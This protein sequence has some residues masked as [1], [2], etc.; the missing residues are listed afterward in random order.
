MYKKL[1]TI[2]SLLCLGLAPSQ[3]NA[4]QVVYAPEFGEGRYILTPKP[5]AAP[6]I[7][8]PTLF[9]VRPGN[10]FLYAIPATGERPMRFSVTALPE[11]LTVNR[12]NGHIEG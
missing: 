6:R 9:G 7:N 12:E 11:G 3:L 8:G 1:I 5:A 4:D 10:P 2:G